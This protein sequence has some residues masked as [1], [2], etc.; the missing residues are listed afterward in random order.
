M[1]TIRGSFWTV[2]TR[3]CANSLLMI[4][5]FFFKRNEAILDTAISEGF[6]ACGVFFFSSLPNC[7]NKEGG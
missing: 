7:G 5:L 3:H 2:D 6:I 4:Y 1:E